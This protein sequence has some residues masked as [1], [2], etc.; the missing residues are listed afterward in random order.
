MP[1]PS[2]DI[3][4]YFTSLGTK[5]RTSESNGG[6]EEPDKKLN[7]NSGKKIANCVITARFHSH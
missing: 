2:K 1:G 4:T 7:K 6:T 5:K 3:K